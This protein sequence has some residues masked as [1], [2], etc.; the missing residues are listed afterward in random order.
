MYRMIKKYYIEEQDGKEIK[1]KQTI[2]E[3]EDWQDLPHKEQV[4]LFYELSA[5]ILQKTILIDKMTETLEAKNNEELLV[6]Q[7]TI[8]NL[9]A[10][11]LILKGEQLFLF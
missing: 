10:V 1:R 9:E 3:F 11:V 4:A 2:H 7:D 6:F 8:K 5:K